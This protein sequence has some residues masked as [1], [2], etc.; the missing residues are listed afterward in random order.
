VVAVQWRLCLSL[1][2]HVF[3]GFSQD[4]SKTDTARITKLDVDMV[5]DKFWKPI[6]FGVKRSKVN[7]TE[8]KKDI[9]RVDKGALVSAGFF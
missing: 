5:H 1:R 4:V 6:Y 7:V 2:L 3:V 9:A 8:H